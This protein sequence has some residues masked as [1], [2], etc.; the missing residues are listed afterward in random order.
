MA[1]GPLE[2]R[3]ASSEEV[4]RAGLAGFSQLVL[5]VP[6][7][8]LSATATSATWADGPFA[9]MR[10]TRFQD[11]GGCGVRVRL[12]PRQATRWAVVSDTTGA[13][14]RPET[15]PGPVVGAVAPRR[16][17]GLFGLGDEGPAGFASVIGGF[18]TSQAENAANSTLH[19]VSANVAQTLESGATVHAFGSDYGER[20]VGPYGGVAVSGLA[21]GAMTG[22]AT[23]GDIDAGSAGIGVADRA[24]DS[25]SIES[26]FLRGIGAYVVTPFR[27]GLRAFTGRPLNSQLMRL[28]GETVTSGEYSNDRVWGLESEWTDLSG[29]L[30]LGLGVLRS[31]PEDGSPQTNMV[32]TLGYFRS[33]D[34]NARLVID[35]SDTQ[36][37]GRRVAGYAATFEPHVHTES[38][39][40]QG[41]VRS[42]S[43]DFRSPLGSTYFA[44]L[45]HSY[46]LVAAYQAT[47]AL[48]VAASLNQTKSFSIFDPVQ[49]GS[50]NSSRGASLGYALTSAVSL[51]ADASRSST[52]SDPGVLLPADSQTTDAGGGIGFSHSGFGLAVHAARERTDNVVAPELSLDSKRLDVHASQAL[53]RMDAVARLSYLDSS[54]PDG[55]SAGRNYTATL[56]VH[57]WLG[58]AGTLYGEIGQIVSPAGI[59]LLQSRQSYATAMLQSSRRFG[60]L[61][62]Y[63]SMNV[64]YQVTD[65]TGTAQRRGW[66]VQVNLGSMLGWGA[67]PRL[68]APQASR[69]LTVPESQLGALALPLLVVNVFEDDNTD[70]VWNAGEAGLAGV[71]V[72]VGERT[73][74]TDGSGRAQIRLTPGSYAVSIGLRDAPAGYALPAL[75]QTVAVPPMAHRSVSFAMVPSARLSG[76]VAAQS[77]PENHIPISGIRLVAQGRTISR[78]AVT[79]EHGEFTFTALPAGEYTVSLDPET[80]AE[81]IVP[82]EPGELLVTLAKGD[83]REVAFTVRRATAREKFGPGGGGTAPMRSNWQN[84]NRN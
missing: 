64:T 36:E 55:E 83:R 5:T 52:V 78:E 27:L 75:S 29:R 37:A 74:T 45:R 66:T 9:T 26:M 38:L 67:G 50:L 31:L 57:S 70:G 34:L 48:S 63:G 8:S 46:D 53:G 58:A 35:R 73:V 19:N 68:V 77:S 82:V 39:N 33:Q 10:A 56:G 80:L 72:Q 42:A 14:I 1:N 3:I 16:G 44:N 65:V 13:L 18:S 4:A 28:G 21:L 61:D 6:R 25:M 40:V 51:S 81:G 49:S 54:R 47:E 60:G 15:P 76:R 30:G 69:A 62:V 22:G 20:D 43:T 59:T 12:Q 17:G 41:F 7:A 11:D 23:F 84:W 24:G 79:D 32:G 2:V 71:R